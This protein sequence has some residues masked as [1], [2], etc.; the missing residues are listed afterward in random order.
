MGLKLKLLST[1][2]ETLGLSLIRLFSISFSLQNEQHPQRLVQLSPALRLATLV[3]L[4]SQ[5]KDSGQSWEEI[6]IFLNHCNGD[7]VEVVMKSGQL[8]G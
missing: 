7:Q 4:L 6:Y 2:L 5:A 3:E 1:S 8:R